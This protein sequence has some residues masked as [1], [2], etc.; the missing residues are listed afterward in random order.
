MNPFNNCLLVAK[1]H[2][3]FGMLTCFGLPLPS[4]IEHM[5]GNLLNGIQ[6]KLKQ[7]LLVEASA[8]CW[9]IWLSRN[10]IIFDKAPMKSFM[11]VLCRGTHWFRYSTDAK[12]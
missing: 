10:D 9:A 11:Q 7:Q 2:A 5:F 4:S 1:M 3:F 8:L 6:T 12:A